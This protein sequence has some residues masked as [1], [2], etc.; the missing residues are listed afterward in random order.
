MLVVNKWTTFGSGIL[1]EMVSGLQYSFSVYSQSIK[2]A[3]HLTQGQVELIGT[4]TNVGN[5][6]FG[7]FAGAAYDMLCSRVPHLAPRATCL[8]ALILCA[9][10][11][12]LL[13]AVTTE[14]IFVSDD[15]GTMTA[16]LASLA[17]VAALAGPFCDMTALAVS[18]QNFP[19]HRG[20][21]M[22]QLKSFL[23]LSTSLHLA[24]YSASR[25]SDST[26]FIL[27]QVSDTFSLAYNG[28]PVGQTPN[29]LLLP[30]S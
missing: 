27:L 25:H 26:D 17:L 24:I 18:A 11:Y 7:I 15:A 29:L 2:S 8:M 5:Y 16:V 28:R 23:G 14:R 1:L 13:W 4:M 22:G 30:H 21:V 10:G 12:P 9:V 19:R 3:H 6:L 20:Q